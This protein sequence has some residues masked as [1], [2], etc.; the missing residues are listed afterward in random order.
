MNGGERLL[1]ILMLFVLSFLGLTIFE[2]KKMKT[3]S[4]FVGIV[5]AITLAGWSNNVIVNAQNFLTGISTNIKPDSI[6]IATSAVGLSLSTFVPSKSARRSVQIASTGGLMMSMLGLPG[7]LPLVIMA[8]L[9]ILLLV[10]IYYFAKKV[11][12]WLS[13]MIKG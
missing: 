9:A 1:G 7:W 10:C 4:F 2:D 5:S 3:L 13:S 11:A 8:T 12:G 6:G